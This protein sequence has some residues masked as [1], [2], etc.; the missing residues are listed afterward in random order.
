MP[1]VIFANRFYWPETPATGQLLADLAPAL[2]A[3]GDDVIV[4][5]SRPAGGALAASESR[6]GVRILRIRTPRGAGGTL[7]GKAVAF[8][9]FLAG[10]TWGMLRHA[11]RGDILVAMTDPP[12][13]GLLAAVVARV[14]GARLVHWVQDIYPEVAVAVTGHRWLRCLTPPRNLAWR[15]ANAVVVVSHEMQAVAI[16]G[17][18]A[19]DRIRV[20]PNWAPHGLVP[21]SPGHPAVVARRVAWQ[22]EGKVVVAYSGNLGRVHDL[23][24]V[25]DAAVALRDDTRIVFVFI[26]GGAQRAAL[27]AAI[28]RQR[29]ANVRFLPPQPRGLLGPALG[30]AD[31][32]LVT[33][34]AGCEPYVFPSKLYGIAAVG[35]PVI[36]V[37]PADCELARVV[38]AH[39]MGCAV[40]T[41]TELADAIRTLAGDAVRRARMAEA[42]AEF[43]REHDGRA[44]LRQWRELLPG[45]GLAAPP[46]AAYAP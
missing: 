43:G 6:D 3:A 34:R 13:L 24:R 18:V 7:G 4:L 45:P 36:A 42:S 23:T 27:Q 8:G 10:V 17:G 38:V 26:G 22:L 32:H 9:T 19:P 33:I 44:T 31:I 30:A 40:V 37:G 16:R 25:I 46:T 11:R 28:D 2:A 35:R 29:L 39:R 5:T 41:A 15:A 1:R 12:L 20:F 14:R 21:L